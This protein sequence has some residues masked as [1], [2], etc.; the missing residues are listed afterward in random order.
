MSESWF[1]DVLNARLKS[2]DIFSVIVSNRHHSSDWYDE[3]CI[4]ED[5]IDDVNIN[6]Q[7]VLKQC[8]LKWIASW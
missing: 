3:N 8:S 2:Y 6:A 1:S 7:D 5:C 4:D